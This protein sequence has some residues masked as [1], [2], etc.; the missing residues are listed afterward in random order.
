VDV[1]GLIW[2]TDGYNGEY[3]TEVE[4]CVLKTRLLFSTSIEIYKRRLW[5]GAF[6]SIN[7]SARGTWRA[8]YY[9]GDFERQVKKGSGNNA[10]LPMGALRRESGG[11]ASLVE[12]LKCM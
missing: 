11:K 1:Q 10:V 3:E 8:S 9:A 6:L 12:P 2:F 5:K 4:I 7:G